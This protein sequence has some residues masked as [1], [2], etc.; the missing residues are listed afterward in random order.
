MRLTEQGIKWVTHLAKLLPYQA[1][2]HS[3]TGLEAEYNKALPF[4]VAMQALH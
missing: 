4:H 3:G 2:L 1:C